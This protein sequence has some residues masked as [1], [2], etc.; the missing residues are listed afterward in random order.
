MAHFQSA[1]SRIPVKQAMITDFKTLQRDESLLRAA[2]PTLSSSQKDYPV[3]SNGKIEG[4]LTQSDL[5]KAL[6]RS[7]SYSEVT[8]AIQSDCVTV[9]PLDT[10]ESTFAKL[11]PSTHKF[12]DEFI[13][14]G[15]S[16]EQRITGK[17]R[18]LL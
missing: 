2:G 12:D 9:D 6:T 4:V 15:L 17:N 14:S 1:V 8:S 5:T 16:A 7:G 10:L 13:C 3:V 18:N 11:S